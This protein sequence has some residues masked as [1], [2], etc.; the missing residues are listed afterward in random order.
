MNVPSRNFHRIFS[1][2]YL[3]DRVC[4]ITAAEFILIFYTCHVQA[5]NWYSWNTFENIFS[6]SNP[7]FPYFSVQSREEEC[8]RLNLCFDPSCTTSGDTNE[9]STLRSTSL[10]VSTEN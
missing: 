5:Y 2:V 10:I 4:T 8:K 3:T 7:P 9:A 6:I 1:E